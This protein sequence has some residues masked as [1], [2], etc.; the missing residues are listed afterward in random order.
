MWLIGISTA[1]ARGT[2]PVQ[3]GADDMQIRDMAA[4]EESAVLALVMRGFDE[5]VRPDF[6]DEGAAEFTAAARSFV[7]DHPTDHRIT[8]AER[9]GCLLGMIDVRDGSHICLFFV[10]RDSRGCGVGRAVLAAAERSSEAGTPSR[11]TVNS[12]LW[13]VPVYE[14]LGFAVTGPT[15]E[16]KGIRAVPMAKETVGGP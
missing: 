1:Q 6:T 10:D 7:L 9:D 3:G 5:F 16:H 12:S 13:A 15:I 2:V 4:G 8:V 14:H 11:I